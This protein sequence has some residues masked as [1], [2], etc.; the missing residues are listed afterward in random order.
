M[1]KI[2]KY[3]WIIHWSAF[4]LLVFLFVFTAIWTIAGIYLTII[5]FLHS[6]ESSDKQF[7]EHL[8]HL[9]ELNTRQIEALFA[10]TERQIEALQKSTHDEISAFEKQIREV[11]NKL[12]D[13]SIL[14]A[15]ILGRELE[16]SIED[17]ANAINDEENRYADLSSFKLLRTQEEREKQLN[18]QL[19]RIQRF[20]QW[21][22]YIVAKY[23]QVKNF[24]NKEQKKL[25]G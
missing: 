11:T 3:K 12:A 21:Y 5:I 25:N 9:Q 14:L 19:S 18:S 20:K 7:R 22:D 13:N 24:L 6:K 17:F 8:E 1:E 23:N 10:S 2:K 15:E 4:S 16:K